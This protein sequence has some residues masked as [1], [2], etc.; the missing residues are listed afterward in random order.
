VEGAG[1]QGSRPEI[2]ALVVQRSHS[3]RYGVH[4]HGALAYSGRHGI[5]ESELIICLE[6]ELLFEACGCKYSYFQTFIGRPSHPIWV[7]AS[8]RESR[9]LGVVVF[10]AGV[11]TRMSTF[12][13]YG[14]SV[15]IASYLAIIFRIGTIITKRSTVV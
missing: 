6:S 1:R 9:I 4:P 11:I 10:S 2:G 14:I 3:V 12:T 15:V 5:T 7:V 13:K 8:C